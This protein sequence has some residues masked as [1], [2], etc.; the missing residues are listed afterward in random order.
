MCG[1]I[2]RTPRP[3][4]V[5]CSMKSEGKAW[6]DLHVMRAAAD[7]TDSVNTYVF[8]PVPLTRSY[9]HNVPPF[10]TKPG[11]MAVINGYNLEAL[12]TPCS[13]PLLWEVQ[14]KTLAA[15]HYFEGKLSVALFWPLTCLRTRSGYCTCL[16]L[17]TVTL[18]ITC[19]IHPGITPPPPPP[20]PPPLLVLL[21][22][23][24]CVGVCVC[25]CVCACACACA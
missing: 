5:A 11:E 23:R 3:A 24:L 19:K 25:V 4:F 14:H 1:L 7:I 20:P 16:E 15:Q 13:E 17:M 8:S 2:S 6:M 22:T 9:L 18:Y 10:G 21:G 12:Y